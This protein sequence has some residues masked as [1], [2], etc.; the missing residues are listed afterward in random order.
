MLIEAARQ[1]PDGRAVGVDLWSGKDQSGNRPEATLANAAAAGV[2][3]RVEVHMG[4]M[5]ALPFAD[6]SFDV[7]TSALA[8]HNISSPEGGTGRWTRP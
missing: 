8:I 6:G 5:T 4:D 7:V 1:L 3:D 2:A